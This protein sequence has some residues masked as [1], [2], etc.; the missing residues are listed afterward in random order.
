[1]LIGSGGE[2]FWQQTG[3]HYRDHNLIIEDEGKNRK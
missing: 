3:V 1:M 2:V